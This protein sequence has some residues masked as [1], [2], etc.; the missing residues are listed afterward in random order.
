MESGQR[1]IAFFLWDIVH[2]GNRFLRQVMIWGAAGS[3]GVESRAHSSQIMPSL[4]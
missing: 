1:I 4:S 2:Q 3:G